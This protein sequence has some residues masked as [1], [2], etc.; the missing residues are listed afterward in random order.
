MKKKNLAIGI[1]CFFI[2]TIPLHAQSAEAKKVIGTWTTDHG[3]TWTFNSNGTIKM[4]HANGKNYQTTNYDS[5]TGINYQMYGLYGVT[6][7]AI[8]TN[9]IMP[10]GTGKPKTNFSGDFDSGA[11]SVYNYYISSDG[12]VMIWQSLAG[13]GIFFNRKK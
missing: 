12:Q 2:F 5:G 11:T 1:I 9:F 8:A 13:G 10:D 7:T 3:Q 6:A 4:T